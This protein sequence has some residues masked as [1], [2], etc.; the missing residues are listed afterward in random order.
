VKLNKWWA[1]LAAGVFAGVIGGAT[2]SQAATSFSVSLAPLIG[3]TTVNEIPQVTHGGKIGYHLVVQNTGTSA[4]Q[5]S[6]IVVTSDFAT[7]SDSNN[8]NCSVNPS[9]AHQLLCTPFDGTLA[10]GAS[11]D[12]KFRYTAPTTGSLVTTSAALT[13]AAQTVGGGNNNGTTLAQSAPVYTNV[14]ENTTRDDTYLHA[15]ENAATGNLNATHLQ[16]FSAQMPPTLLGDLFGVALSIH[17]EVGTPICATCL[18]AFT[19]LTMPTAHFATLPGNPFS[20]GTTLNPYGWTMSAQ[21]PPGFRLTRL[22]HVDDNAVP[23]DV[24]SCASVGG[25]PSVAEPICWDVLK[26]LANQKIAF[27]SGRGLEN[28]EFGFG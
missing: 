8:A 12:V 15:N 3:T 5:H 11:F 2:T 24:P 16:N 18:S 4:A 28:G 21:Y 6:T 14:T 22:V 17:D 13:I 7:F 20:D 23:D 25:G 26:Q 27:A 10:A 19:S 1:L 9:D